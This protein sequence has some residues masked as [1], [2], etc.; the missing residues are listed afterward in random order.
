MNYIFDGT[1][2]KCSLLIVTAISLGGIADHAMGQTEKT[3]SQPQSD[4]LDRGSLKI[5][6]AMPTVDLQDFRGKRWSLGK[7]QNN[8]P[9][10]VVFFGVECPLVKLYSSTL[11]RLQE[12]F[13]G[14][15]TIVGINSNR[16]DSITEIAEFA[17][18]TKTEYP[19]LKDPANRVADAF[20]AQRT[21][22]VY[23]FDANRKLVYRGAIDDQ[24]SY[25]KQKP[26]AD[27][28]YL[29]DAIEA[30]EDQRQPEVQFVEAEGCLIGRVLV[31]QDASQITYSNQISRLLNDRC[32]QCHRPGEVAPFSL[33]D[34][35]EVVGWAEMIAEVVEERR[36]PP[37]N[38]NPDHGSFKN[39]ASL[40]AAERSLIQT[41]VKNGAPFGKAKELPEP[42]K[43]VEGWQIGTPD[44]VTQIRKTPYKVPAN[45]VVPYEHFVV[46]PGFKEDKWVQAAEIRIDNRAVVHHVVVVADS[47]NQKPVHGEIDSEW[48]TAAAPGSTPLILPEGYAKLIPAGSKLIFQMHYTTNGTS[49]E[50]NSYIGFKFI[51]KS[52]VKKVVGTEK[53][54]NRKGLVIPPHA[55][56]HR[57]AASHRFRNK[58]ELLALFPHMHVRGKS[59]KYILEKPGQKPET[60]LDVPDYDF[61]WQHGYKFSEPI[62]VPRGSVMRCIAHYDNSAENF[63]NPD[64]SKTVRWGD[65]TWEEMMIG[66][67]DMALA[68]QDLTKDKE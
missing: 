42:R 47:R 66:Y 50:D 26:H 37:W 49:Q 52:K 68:D 16:H 13:E 25:G 22:E 17:K 46:D 32:V 19:L 33:T 54:S 29:L 62:I 24:C 21:P 18:L 3:L 8:Q 5:G 9:L 38:A 11:N 30:L 1:F 53:A 23:L 57:V 56:K 43:F 51:D 12:K 34:Y 40:T 4:T 20:G 65:Q 48:I 2:A 36:M 39:D 41:W 44:F 55:K 35:D 28:R 64:P 6:D 10:A 61:N 58:T 31:S 7:P 27:N 45:G 15:L 14:R 60:L 67:F 59:F 63:A